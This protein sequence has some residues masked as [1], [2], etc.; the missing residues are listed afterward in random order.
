MSALLSG[1]P[2]AI[3]GYDVDWFKVALKIREMRLHSRSKLAPEDRGRL[4]YP[5][6]VGVKYVLNIVLRQ[7]K[8]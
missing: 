2:E 1:K 3:H 7:K 8:F 6:P 5:Q 4:T